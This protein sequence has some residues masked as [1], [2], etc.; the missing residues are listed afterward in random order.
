MQGRFDG[1]EPY[2][3]NSINSLGRLDADSMRAQLAAMKVEL[4]K[5]AEK[6]ATVTPPLAIDAVIHHSSGDDQVG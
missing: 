3:T 1:I 6:S 5:L 2:L 4:T